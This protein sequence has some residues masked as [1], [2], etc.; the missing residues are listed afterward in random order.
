[1]Q[2]K[3]G[4]KVI[5]NPERV[6]DRENIGCCGLSINTEYT[7]ECITPSGKIVLEGYLMLLYPQDLIVVETSF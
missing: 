3:V 4:D 5:R 2:I 7:V 6:K 1:M